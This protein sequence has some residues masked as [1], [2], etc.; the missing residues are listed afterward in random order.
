MGAVTCDLPPFF[1]LVSGR[2]PHSF[3]RFKGVRDVVSRRLYCPECCGDLEIREPSAIPHR[4]TNV[5]LSADCL[6]CCPSCHTRR[7]NSGKVILSPLAIFSTFTNDTL[8]T[9]RS[10]PL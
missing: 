2:I 9:P 6:F 3:A 7:N 5:G 10:T 1:R 8:R 4:L